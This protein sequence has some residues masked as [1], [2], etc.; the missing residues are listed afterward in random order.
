MRPRHLQGDP[1]GELHECF[2]E[3][4]CLYFLIKAALGGE[5]YS[6]YN[7]KGFYGRADHTK[8]YVAGVVVAI[9]HLHER[10]IVYRD[11]KPENLLLTAKGHPKNNFDYQKP[12][13][14]EGGLLGCSAF[15][16]VDLVENKYQE[17]NSRIQTPSVL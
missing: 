5:L 17:F 6:T 16:A 4:Q 14:S 8:F 15:G 3:P 12:I 2:I 11:L 9:E 13:H 7:S 10:R 1:E